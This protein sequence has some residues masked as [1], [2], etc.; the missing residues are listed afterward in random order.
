MTSE[1]KGV[2]NGRAG[3]GG[4]LGDYYATNVVAIIQIHSALNVWMKL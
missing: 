3:G 2:G 4:G 1:E